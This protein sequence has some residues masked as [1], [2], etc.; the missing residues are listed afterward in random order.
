MTLHPGQRV[1]ILTNGGPF[2]ALVVDGKVRLCKEDTPCKG[3]V[4]VQRLYPPT[5]GITGAG[6]WT[7]GAPVSWHVENLQTK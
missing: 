7:L 3:R 5:P 4:A 1:T 6:R 2:P